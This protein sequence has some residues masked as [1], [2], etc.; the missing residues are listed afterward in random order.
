MPPKKLGQ[1][2]KNLGQRRCPALP[3]SYAPVADR[4]FKLEILLWE[5][6][7][8]NVVITLKSVF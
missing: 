8:I 4:R 1:R 6:F 3:Q 5:S 7:V 2:V